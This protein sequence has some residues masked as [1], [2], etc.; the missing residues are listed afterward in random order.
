MTEG[1][2]YH[3]D[4]LERS[5]AFHLHVHVKSLTE[6]QAMSALNKGTRIQVH[7]PFGG[8]HDEYVAAGAVPRVG[9]IFALANFPNYGSA[10]NVL[11]IQ[12]VWARNTVN[13]DEAEL[14]AT[15]TTKLME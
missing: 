3:G 10:T 8:L 1:K 4:H 7:S 14:V 6:R 2:A 5:T 12:V 9:E 15:L 13:Q 11:I